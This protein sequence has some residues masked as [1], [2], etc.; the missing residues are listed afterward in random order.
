MHGVE[1]P[2][3][4]TWSLGVE[5]Q[6]YLLWPLLFVGVALVARS[7]LRRRRSLLALFGASAVV[8]F[9]L[10]LWLTRRGSPW[11]F[12]SL[13]TRAWEFAAAGILAGA[14]VPR[15]L[16]HRHVRTG[17]YVTGLLLLGAATVLFHGGDPYPGVRA[18]VPVAAT[19]LLILAGSVSA[20]AS[21]ITRVLSLAPVQRLGRLSYSWYLWHWPIMIVAVA[22]LD[23]DTT[24][25]RV[26]AGL[27]AL[28]PAAAAYRWVENPVRFHSRLVVSPVRTIAM[29]VGV[30]ALVIGAS[31]T[32]RSYSA[33]ELASD[34]YRELAA[35][36]DGPRGL[37]CDP[38]E[39][40]AT[41]IEYCVGGDPTSST[42]VMLIGDSHA[43][44]WSRA[45]SASAE[46][47]HV[48]LVVRAMSVCP[49]IPLRVTSFEGIE[50]PDCAAYRNDT[51]SLIDELRPDA[52]VV[53]DYRGYADQILRPDGAHA[54]PA[55]QA[56]LW[57]TA[58]AE[59]MAAFQELGVRV[60][61]V[62]DNPRLAFDPLVCMS[63]RG[64]S[65]Q[66]CRPSR[67]DALARVIPFERAEQRVLQQTGEVP[68]FGVTDRICDDA[69]CDLRQNGAFVF[70][71]R[72]HLAA[73]WTMQHSRL[74]DPFL[75][76]LNE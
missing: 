23:R 50:K 10:S 3:L 18:L 47:L 40:S 75:K 59:Q 35:V 6:F 43:M 31:F 7:A 13:P 70:R 73:A 11:A 57:R 5:E 39:R 9:A 42:T 45:F 54:D 55:E 58:F 12:F 41:G 19:L 64:N 15:Q 4:H 56:E 26:A 60:G 25:V 71:D 2:F 67:A 48:R 76:E 1:S 49:S 33:H 62:V 72:D 37:D 68:T 30:T 51:R 14:T 20:P 22:W 66:S 34:G 29:G 74:I 69:A 36:K 46:R 16:Q 21:T 38:P 52:V 61:V 65:E 44:Q 28:A 27:L 53:S 17:A 63:R 24:T 32:F 8:S